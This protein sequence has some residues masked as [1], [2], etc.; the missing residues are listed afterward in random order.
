MTIQDQ[1]ELENEMMSL[2][3]ERYINNINKKNEFESA[4]LQS[5]VSKIILP[6]S[7]CIKSITEEQNNNYTRGHEPPLLALSRKRSYETDKPL[8]SDQVSFIVCR[9]LLSSIRDKHHKM[10]RLSYD[11][12]NIINQNLN[13]SDRLSESQ[14]FRLGVSLVS[15]FCDKFN[16]LVKNELGFYDTK[17]KNKEYLIQPTEEFL[18]FIEDK[19]EDIAEFNNVMY[20]MIHIPCDW[21]SHGK[22]GGF[23]SDKL[24]TNIIKRRTVDED[25]GINELIANSINLIQSTPW[26]VNDYIKDVLDELNKYKP[27][28]LKKLYPNKVP[29]DPPRPFSED[30]AYKDLNDE[31]KKTHQLWRRDC[32]RY[33]KNRKANQSIII[34][35]SASMKQAARFKNKTIYF[36]HDADYRVRTYNRCMTGLNTQGD[37]NQKGL[38][39][40]A[41]SRPIKTASGARWMSINLANLVGHDKLK[42]DERYSW[43]INNEDLIRDVVKDPIKCDLWHSWDKPLQGLA[44]ANEYVKWLNNPEASINTHVQLDGLCNGCQHLTAITKDEQ[45]A[46]HVGLVYTEERGDVYQYVCDATIKQITGT[47]K[48]SDEWISSGLMT[49]SLPKTPVMTRSLT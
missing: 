49:R 30:I 42:L 35:R 14:L 11:V 46:P 47:G 24:K 13:V 25:S 34:S 28:S 15:M 2:G 45:V 1:L 37:D 48:F 6:F 32:S 3:T 7:E 43:C 41:N 31:Q 9:E 10:V 36:P 22:G 20:P 39:Q 12:G 18:S 5:I 40:L 16:L 29:S 27:K 23:Y 44:A 4:H 21:N 19:I 38:I 26:K 17:S 8:N 33:E